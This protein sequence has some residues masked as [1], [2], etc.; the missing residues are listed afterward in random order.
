MIGRMPIK[1]TTMTKKYTGLVA[2]CLV[3]C[4]L[5]TGCAGINFGGYFQHL[6]TLLS[7]GSLMPFDRMEYTRPDMTNFQTVTEQCCQEAAAHKNLEDMVQTIYSFY[8]AYDDFYTNFALAMIR[9]SQNQIDTHWMEEYQFC[10]QNTAHVDAALDRFY[11]VLAKSSLREQLEGEDYFG[12]GFFNNYQGESIYDAYFTE[13]LNKE[14][15]LENAYYDIIAQAGGDYGYS[16]VFYDTYGYRMA[17]IFVELVALRQEQAEYAGYENY[18]EFAYDFYH[19]RDYTPAQAVSYLADIRAELAPLYIGLQTRKPDVTLYACEENQM[20]GYVQNVAQSMGGEIA[21]AF[22][23]MQSAGLYDIG[24]SENKLDASFEI[25]LRNYR[26][27][28]VFVNPSGTDYDKLTFAHEFG[29]FCSDYLSYGSGAGVDVS[30]IFSQGME[31]LSLCYG[32]Q[33]TNLTKLKMVDSLC[34]FVEQAAYASFEHRVYGLEGEELTVEN[35]Q[36]LYDGICDG[37]GLTGDWTYVLINHFFTEP[38][39]VISYVVS[40]DAALQLYQMEQDKT[41]AGL[42]CLQRNMTT[43]KAYFL[44]FL[45]EAGLKSPFTNGRVQEVKET[46]QSILGL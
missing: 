23:D 14:A 34:I 5:F 10:T 12:P 41:G 25:Y 38:M 29:H 33:D 11:R 22:A 20:L 31:Y 7:G 8:N 45:Q 36:A 15:E 42:A 24:Y 43:T 9:Y 32:N 2:L 37:Y 39:Y 4:L 13:L 1:E 19:I 26:S 28:F 21:Q 6:F 27:P 40:N 18:P 30:E 35:V 17:E 46:L 16:Q 44:A 3:V